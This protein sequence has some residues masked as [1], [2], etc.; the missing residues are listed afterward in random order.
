MFTSLSLL[1]V[2]L[3]F[4]MVDFQCM[5]FLLSVLLSCL[6]WILLFV[7]NRRKNSFNLT[8]GFEKIAKTKNRHT[9]GRFPSIVVTSGIA[10]S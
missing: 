6:F 5:I 9:P 8:Q 4:A 2:N 10:P 7:Y 3:D 1:F